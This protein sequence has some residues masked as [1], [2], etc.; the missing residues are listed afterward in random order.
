MIR[1]LEFQ[2][3]CQRHSDE[4]YRYARSLLANQADAEDAT[5]EVLLRLLVQ[6]RRAADAT[7]GDLADWLGITQSEVSKHE[8]GER[9]LDFLQVRSWVEAL[10][11]PF[12]AFVADFEA[13]LSRD[14]LL[15][16]RSGGRRKT[17]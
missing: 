1:E 4:I 2:A 13:E 5:Q 6:A 12:E 3:L 10:G 7:Q 15:A 9:G 14:R 16:P 11:V 8:R 17:S